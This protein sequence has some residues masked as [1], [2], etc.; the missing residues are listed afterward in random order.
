[1]DKMLIMKDE[2]YKNN[3]QRKKYILSKNKFKQNY[4]N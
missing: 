2:I 1:M 4:N 3:Y